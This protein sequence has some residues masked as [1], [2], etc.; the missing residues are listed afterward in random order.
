M[1]ETKVTDIM[2]ELRRR[3][4]DL[5]VRD[6]NAKSPLWGSPAADARGKLLAEWCAT[7]DLVVMNDG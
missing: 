5:I 2:T 3:G 7:L 6:F 4:E 1:F